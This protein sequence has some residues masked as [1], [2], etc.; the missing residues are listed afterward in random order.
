MIKKKN[1][2]PKKI[3]EPEIL[4]SLFLEYKDWCKANP[5][6]ENMPDYKAATSFAV[7]RERPMTWD[8][9]EVW[10]FDQG[11]IKRLD[12]Y[13]ANKEGRYTEFADIISR[14][15][16]IIRTDKFE[17]ATVGIYN[18]NIIARDLGLIDK[19]ETSA[20]VD[21]SALNIVP[22]SEYV[23]IHGKIPTDK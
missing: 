9:F 17:G 8:G 18:H 2:R 20:K 6:K 5:R 21:V 11:I 10:L 19:S 12:D 23:K 1:R 7:D 16:K 3:S 13:R 4:Y 15:D 22:A 14:I